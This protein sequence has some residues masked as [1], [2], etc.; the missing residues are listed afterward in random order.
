M[1]RFTVLSCIDEDEEQSTHDGPVVALGSC[2]EPNILLLFPITKENSAI[3]KYVLNGEGDFDINTNILGIYKTMVDSWKTADKYL[4]GIIVDT[5][6]DQEL[7]DDVIFIR[8]ALADDNG[9]LDSLVHINFV[10]GVLLAAM[11]KIDLI[12]SD[13]VLGKLIPSEEKIFEDL[14]LS[15]SDNPNPDSNFP[16]DKN[17]LNIVKQIMHGKIEE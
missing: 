5:I 17:L 9:E 10:H 11:E 14:N 7:D 6:Y 13:N 8:L 3:I 2:S 16:E 12:F 4:C 15:G 1:N